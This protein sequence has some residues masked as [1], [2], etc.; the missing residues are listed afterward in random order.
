MYRSCMDVGESSGTATDM[1]E[2]QITTGILTRL[3]QAT[4]QETNWDQEI[5]NWQITHSRLQQLESNV[6]RSFVNPILMG[7]ELMVYLSKS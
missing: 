3:E 7:I 5:P 1:D 2:I 6:N 4:P